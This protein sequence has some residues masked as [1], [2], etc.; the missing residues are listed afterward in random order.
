MSFTE[1]TVDNENMDKKKS[2]CCCIFEKQKLFGESSSEDEDEG[3]AFPEGQHV[4]LARVRSLE[5]PAARQQP[6][7]VW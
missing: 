5:Q 3:K 6:A 2:K 1:E 7:R 4:A